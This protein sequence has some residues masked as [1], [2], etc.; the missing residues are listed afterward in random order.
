MGKIYL[1]MYSFMDGT[2][3]DTCENLRLAAAM[4]YDGV[5]L[6]GGNFAVPAEEMKRQ[7]ETYGL[8]AVSMHAQTGQIREMIPYAKA[9]GMKF[10]GIG[11]EVMKNEK[12]VYSF[13]DTL[14]EL[15]EE[16]AAHGITL[17]YHNHTQE[18]NSCNGKRIIDVLVRDTDP[19]Y[20][21][22]ELDAGW[23][24]AAGADPMFLVKQYSGRFKLIHVK[25]SSRVIGPQP[26]MD[27]SSFDKDADGNPVLPE[28]VKKS[29]EESRAINCPAGQGLVDWKLLKET[30]DQNGCEAYI[31]ERE[32]TYAGTRAECLKADIDYYRTVI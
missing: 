25:E 9:L 31:V 12:D 8:E 27:F 20:V 22:F 26:P 6:F 13:A 18:F 15:G 21:S 30:A 2:M 24:A 32:T 3:N 7:L 23:C 17:T 28:A 4:G 1:Q 16:C 10:M 11:M 19:S 5:E 29:M 14:N